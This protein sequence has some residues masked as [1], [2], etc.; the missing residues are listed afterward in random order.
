VVGKK[1]TGSLALEYREKKQEGKKI[2]II[3]NRYAPAN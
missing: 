3:S 1:Y 2:L